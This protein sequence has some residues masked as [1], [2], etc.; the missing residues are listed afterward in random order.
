MSQKV[1]GS[2]RIIPKEKKRKKILKTRVFKVE[3][4]LINLEKQ[5][6]AR[7]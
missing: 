6:L 1:E 3:Y 2:N 4:D 7:L 5:G